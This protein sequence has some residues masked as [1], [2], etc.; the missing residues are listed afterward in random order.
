MDVRDVVST[1]LDL[2]MLK[3][4]RTEYFIVNDKVGDGFWAFAVS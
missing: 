1:L 4:I 3:Y 2:E